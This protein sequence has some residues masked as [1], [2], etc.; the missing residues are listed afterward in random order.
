[1]PELISYLKKRDT[2]PAVRC[3]YWADKTW[4]RLINEV[5]RAAPA[6]PP[7]TPAMQGDHKIEQSFE[8]LS[9]QLSPERPRG[10][11]PCPPSSIRSNFALTAPSIAFMHQ[12]PRV[13]CF[14]RPLRR[15]SRF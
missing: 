4:A 15:T 6:T 3:Q 8:H 7:S 11:R 1:M 13:N 14:I 12:S 2:G 10:P 5:S 9:T